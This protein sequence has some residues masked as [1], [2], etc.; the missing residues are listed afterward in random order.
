M[1][2]SL[3]CLSGSGVSLTR[4]VSRILRQGNISYT[5]RPS[6]CV[7]LV[8]SFT[9]MPRDGIC[10]IV[11]S[12]GSFSNTLRSRNCLVVRRW[13]VSRTRPVLKS[14]CSFVG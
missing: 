5:P 13:G 8:A 2:K 4:P 14:I 10:L 9:Y 12:L 3:S 7:G 11:R 1:L 6:I